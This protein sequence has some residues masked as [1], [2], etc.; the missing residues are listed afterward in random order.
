VA[1]AFS[2]WQ[3]F[4]QT[5]GHLSLPPS[6]VPSINILILSR[7]KG[8]PSWMFGTVAIV[9][10]LLWDWKLLVSIGVGTMI[11]GVAYAMQQ[12]NWGGF[13]DVVRQFFASPNRPLAVAVA[14]GGLSALGIYAAVAIW[15]TVENPWI[16]ALAI[17]QGFATIV[18]LAIL[19]G[20]NLNQ[21]LKSE[22][23]STLDDKLDGLTEAD[24]LKRLIAVR[25]ILRWVKNRTIEKNDRRTVS[26][27]LRLMLQSET[28]SIVLEAVLEGLQELDETKKIASGTP[29]ISLTR[30][31]KSP[32]MV[33]LKSPDSL[34]SQP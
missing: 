4:L 27:A 26:E 9:V 34:T 21:F 15:T 28:E 23:E 17:V 14:S 13:Q 3:Q 2:S 19:L 30:S 24:P 12:W 22:T 7:L 1:Q 32:A 33:I 10:L 20:Q 8:S 11:L 29:P 5:L 6:Q 25:K 18:I 16:A 31:S